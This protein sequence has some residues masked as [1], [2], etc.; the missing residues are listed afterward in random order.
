VLA[1]ADPTALR[2]GKARVSITL[3]GDRRIDIRVDVDLRRRDRMALA[4]CRT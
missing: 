4:A 3:K 2:G 1:K